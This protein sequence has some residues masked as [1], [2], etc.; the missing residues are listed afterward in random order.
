MLEFL[1]QITDRLRRYINVKVFIAGIGSDLGTQIAKNLESN[2]AVEEIAGID[3]FPPRRYLARTKFFMSHFDDSERIADVINQFSPDVIINFGVYEPGARLNLSKARSATS[4]VLSGIIHA[5]NKIK[6]KHEVHV[7]TRSSVAVYGFADPQKTYDETSPT[8][9]DTPYGEMCRHVEEELTKNCARLSIVRTAPE[10]GAH[11]PHPLA[12]LLNHPL[13]P[14]QFRMPFSPDPGFPAISTRDVVQV[15]LKVAEIKFENTNLHRT[16]HAACPANISML[17][18]AKAGKK[19]PLFFY[20]P[21]FS[22][23]KKL[24]YLSG[25]PIDEHI[26]MFIRRGM[27]IDSTSTRMALKISS[28][29]SPSEIL[30]QLFDGENKEVDSTFAP[31]VFK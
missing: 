22:L 30:S 17:T 6:Q 20:G 5:V 2:E 11:V 27:K 9:P 12:R 24:S 26:E 29:D 28:Q 1:S 8:C 25:A 3:M 18:A 19:M 10:I 15:F 7:I 16:F 23:A 13:I 31:E 21:G 4:A 14:V